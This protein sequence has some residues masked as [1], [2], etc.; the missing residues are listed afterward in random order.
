LVLLDEAPV[1]VVDDTASAAAATGKDNAAVSAAM[2][3]LD[4]FGFMGLSSKV[5]AT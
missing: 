1:D 2:D 5:S 4:K 3:K